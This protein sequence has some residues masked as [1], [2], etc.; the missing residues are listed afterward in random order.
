MGVWQRIH[1][2]LRHAVRTQAARHPDCI[3]AST[4][5]ARRCLSRG[6]Q[7]RLLLLL[8]HSRLLFCNGDFGLRFA[9]WR[10]PCAVL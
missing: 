5:A 1:E 6:P 9:A 2:S 4:T 10:R 3:N 7:S 8:R